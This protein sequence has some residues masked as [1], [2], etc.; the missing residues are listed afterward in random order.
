[1]FE[2]T[3]EVMTDVMAKAISGK[4]VA[5]RVRG[6][7]KAECERLKNEKSLT[8]GLAVVLVGKDHASRVYVRNKTRACEEVG[9]SSFQHILSREVKQEK[10]LELVSGLNAREDVHGILVQLPLPGH[11]NAGSVLEAISPEKDVDG[12]HPFNV[13]RLVTGRPLFEPCTP[14]GIMEL[15]DSAAIE[16]SGKDAVVVGRSNI[17]GKPTAF[18]LLH[19]HA[20]V[21]ICHSRTTD[22]P[23]KVNSADIVVA[24]VGRAGFVK[25]EWIREGAVVVDVGMNRTPEGGLVGDVEFEGASKRASYI[26]PVPGGVGPMTV[27]MLLKNTVEAAKRSCL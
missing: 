2:Y 17:V 14:R 12:F 5:L 22:L 19:R 18:M 20:T 7:L 4:E 16:I 8:P 3:M 27:A 15:L 10:L 11:I 25:G 26:T 1:M 23:A 6:E 24:A 13:G 21:T 9:I